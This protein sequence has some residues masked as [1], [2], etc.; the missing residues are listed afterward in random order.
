[1]RHSTWNG[2]YI[3]NR[4]IITV[5]FVYCNIDYFLRVSKGVKNL[6]NPSVIPYFEKAL[7]IFNQ[8]YKSDHPYIKVV[9]EWLDDCR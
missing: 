8:F 1:M 7:A 4:L 2:R 9:K 6:P 3:G 5:S